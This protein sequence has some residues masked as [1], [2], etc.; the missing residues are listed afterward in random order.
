MLTDTAIDDRFNTLLEFIKMQSLDLWRATKNKRGLFWC[1]YDSVRQF[2]N[3][4]CFKCQFAEANDLKN[5]DTATLLQLFHY[6]KEK[7]VMFKFIISV[8]ENN[9]ID[10]TFFIEKDAFKTFSNLG[11]RPKFHNGIP[12]SKLK[13][14]KCGNCH[15]VSNDKKYCSK[16]GTVCYCNRICQLK[17]W[18]IHKM[19][20]SRLANELKSVK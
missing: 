15:N 4:N 14:L 3:D 10:R 6:D 9:Y 18:P 11:Y 12:D 17:H 19:V 5:L 13:I 20:C 1:E 8:S 16:C 2:L 7:T